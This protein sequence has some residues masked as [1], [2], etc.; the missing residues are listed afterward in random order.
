MIKKSTLIKENTKLKRMIFIW[1]NIGIGIN[2]STKEKEIAAKAFL[3]V[4]KDYTLYE[5]SSTIKIAKGTLYNFLNNKVKKPWFELK[6]ERLYKEIKTIFVESRKTYGADRL[7]IALRKKNIFTSSKTVLAIMKKYNLV[8]NNNQ[9]RPKPVKKR[10]IRNYHRNILKREFNQDAPNKVW[11][12]DFLEINVRGVKFYLCVI[13]D[14]Y[15][16]RV[17]AWRL[18]HKRSVNL[19]LNTFKDAFEIRSEPKNLIFHTD[20]GAEYTSKI[21][22]ESL[23][24]LGVIQSFSYP[25]SP[26]DNACMESFYGTL[27]REEININIDKYENSLIINQYL[28][29]YFD[30][31]NNRRMHTSNIN[32]LS[33]VEMED[34]YIKNKQ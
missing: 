30:Y 10:P 7:V 19:A 14:L 13:L 12:S 8:K 25:G 17:I 20:Q 5:I 9:N 28:S 31:Y 26:Y 33:P 21:F 6:E 32:K 24:M 29:S 34:Y 15:A 22:I 4:N 23:K 1:E 2:S 18:S 27:R 11:A 3:D 16:R